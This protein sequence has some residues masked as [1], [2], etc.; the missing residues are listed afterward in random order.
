MLGKLHRKI[1]SAL[2]KSQ[3]FYRDLSNCRIIQINRH[4]GLDVLSDIRV[5]TTSDLRIVFDV[6]AN[7]GQSARAYSK[8]LPNAQIYCFEPVLETFKQLQQN[9][10]E[11]NNAY[12]FQLALG[13][14]EKQTE[15]T[16][17]KYSL[18]NSLLN[19]SD[20]A[21]S[22]AEAVRTEIIQVTT[23]SDFCQNHDIKQIDF[24]K[25]D[26]EGYDLEVLRG[27]KSLLDD[28]KITYIQVEA[29]MNYN[30]KKH[31]PIQE[32]IRYLESRGYVL[33]GIYD[34]MAWFQNKARLRFCNPVFISEREVELRS[35]EGIDVMF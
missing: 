23:I 9:T 19:Y 21:L 34:Q 8:Y 14:E 30:N 6:G 32:F 25:V 16:L 28:H 10:S 7:V 17:Q 15:I 18:E 31:V 29:G 24:L 4:H 2:Q 1:S 20:I 35:R 26:T 3:K 13:P 27:A 11:C 12:C 33:F 22:E 5:R